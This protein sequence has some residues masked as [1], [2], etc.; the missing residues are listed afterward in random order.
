VAACTGAPACRSA[1]GETRRLARALAQS[2]AELL[3][4]GARLHVSGC[5]KSCAHSG[6]SALTLVFAA[7]GVHLGRDQSAADAAR[8]PAVRLA[9]APGALRALAREYATCSRAE[10][11]GAPAAFLEPDSEQPE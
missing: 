5:A 3:R 2:S 1:H 6:A 7:D 4:Q 8:E 9:D 11:C 10:P